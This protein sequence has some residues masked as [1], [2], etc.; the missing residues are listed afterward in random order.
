MYSKFYK[1]WYALYVKPRTEKKVH[2]MLLRHQLESYLPL[3]KKLKKWSDRKKII[4]E[5]LFSSY[6]FVYVKEFKDFSKTLLVDG[7]CNFIRFNNDYARI[8][9]EEISNIKILLEGGSNIEV[10]NNIPTVGEIRKINHGL[11]KGLECL[12][13]KIN[14]KDKV[15]VK[16]E[17]IRLNLVATLPTNYLSGQPYPIAR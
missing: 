14:N 1:G 12:I 15:V 5:P 13:L 11:L 4:L 10:T 3:V 16:I 2:K 6:V 7:A 8:K 17:S 9:D